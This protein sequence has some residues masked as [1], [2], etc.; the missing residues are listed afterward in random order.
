[1]NFKERLQDDSG[2]CVRQ[3]KPVLPLHLSQGTVLMNRPCLFG[4]GGMK[5]TIYSVDI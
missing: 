4:T 3:L 5:K 2:T 1:M